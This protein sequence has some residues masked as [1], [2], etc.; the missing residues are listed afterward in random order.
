[1]VFYV[2]FECYQFLP[3]QSSQKLINDKTN[4]PLPT[5]NYCI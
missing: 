1:M 5:S 3:A 4:V 2:V